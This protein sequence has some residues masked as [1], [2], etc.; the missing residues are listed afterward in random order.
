MPNVV[1][2]NANSSPGRAVTT[3][4]VVNHRNGPRRLKPTNRAGAPSRRAHTHAPKHSGLHLAIRVTSATAA[5]TWPGSA[6]IVTDSAT[7]TLM[8]PT[9]KAGI[10]ARQSPAM[11]RPPRTFMIAVVR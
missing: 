10:A 3:A 7:S 9:I 1:T 2:S 6:P 11:P 4:Q 5:Y 8:G